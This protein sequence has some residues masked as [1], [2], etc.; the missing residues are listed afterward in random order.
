[1]R[2]DE[3][4]IGHHESWERMES[5]LRRA[6]GTRL[7]GLTPDEVMSLA[8]LY[9]RSTADLA[10]AQ[11]DWPGEPVTR[12]LNGLVARGHG[13]LYREGG[14]IL[15]RLRTFYMETLP[16]T[17]RATWKYFVVAAV[18]LFLPAIV[19]Y[20][21]VWQNPEAANSLVPPD[22]VDRV[23]HHQL[24]TD[25]PP[26]ER[27]VVASGIMTNNI[28]V[29]ILAFAFGTL[30]GLPT[31]YVLIGNGI[32]IGGVLGLTRAYGVDG[33]LLEFMVGHGVLEL[34]IIVASGAAGLMMG[35][36]LVYPGPHRRR[37]ALVLATRRA[38]VLLA[39]LAP[40]LVIAGIIE[41]NI[42]PS[43][44]PLGVKVGIGG[45]TGVLLYGYLLMVGR[46]ARAQL[47]EPTLDL[48]RA[49]VER[50]P[51]APGI[52]EPGRR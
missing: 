16:G 17:F 42:S 8:A 36:A 15:R 5:L 28:K 12:Y 50:A 35:W 9:R 25:I 52:A 3:F 29:A 46:T 48:L 21:V 22:I 1:M 13:A 51:S 27:P 24:W 23:H 45:A 4:V 19:A 49:T 10:R 30:A 2:A 34:S 39:G 14:S 18:L 47:G 41:G 26:D 38:F 40:L 11:R 32:N 37:D 6:T 7:V 44:A 20:F 33:G 43:A 31:V